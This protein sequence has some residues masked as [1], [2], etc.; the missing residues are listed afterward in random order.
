MR[1][2]IHTFTHTRKHR[3]HTHNSC[4]RPERRSPRAR[5]QLFRRLHTLYADT[6]SNPFHRL[7]SEL[8][9]CASFERQVERVVEAG[10]Y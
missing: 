9:G 7:D 2:P 1:I 3:T 10:L 6:V 8:N 4:P 5:P